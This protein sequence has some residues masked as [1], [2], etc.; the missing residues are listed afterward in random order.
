VALAGTTL[1][2]A[3]QA[4]GLAHRGGT[5]TVLM[6]FTLGS[7][8]P[9]GAYD[10]F[11]GSAISLT[12][13]GLTG[14]KRVGGS[15]GARLV[16]DLATSLPAPTDGGRTYT[17]QLRPGIHYSTG[18]LVRPADFRRALER[19]LVTQGGT[20]FYFSG[21]VGADRCVK[22]PKRCALSH[23]IVADP[24][25][26]TVTF[27]LT[28]PDP[29]FLYKL[30]QPA[31]SAVPAGTPLHARLPLPATGPYMIASYNAKHGVRLVRNPHFREW[32]AAAQPS[33]YPN[34][35]V[36]RTS[37][38]DKLL[39][40]AAERGTADLIV[41]SSLVLALRT[42]YASQFRT[43]SGPTTLYVF[44]NTR[45]PPFNNLKARRAVNYALDRNRAVELAGGPD[46]KQPSCQVLPP[47]F[48]GYRPYCP[49]T[50]DPR[51]DGTYTGPDLAKA[52]K[53]V[54]A[55]GTRGQAVTVSIDPLFLG[56][57]GRAGANFVSTLQ[58]LGYRARLEVIPDKPDKPY[59]AT[60]ADSRSRIQ[61][62]VIGWQTDYL[63]P[64]NFFDTLL[65]CRSYQPRSP[66]N[67]NFAEFCNRRIDTEIERARS[68][69]TT[70]PQ[71]ASQ[72]WSKVDRD[73][74]D[75]APWTVLMNP[76]GTAFVSRR[77][78]NYQYNPQWGALL[79]RLWVVK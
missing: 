31:A 22:K 52:R 2:V 47:N 26:N 46:V 17:F 30:T 12:Y 37:V 79:D 67:L 35:V 24:A 42:R 20:G 40:R 57:V 28:T 45:L 60:I 27:H 38:P 1:Y 15:D 72:L 29:D 21:I 11:Y 61:A 73:V 41:A 48:T 5:L 23:G 19:S 76:R 44:L 36:L 78:R 53:L 65:S 10:A 33:G 74:V 50:I 70:D 59:N 8:D 32:S 3:V 77:I 71:A 75:Q 54:S 55:S 58:S 39:L 7:V 34:Q 4:S 49:Y 43:N 16:P 25:S 18:T 13:D 68:L 14:Y 51:A 62:G 69:Q 64:S 66:K 63:S 6:P 56:F 9:A